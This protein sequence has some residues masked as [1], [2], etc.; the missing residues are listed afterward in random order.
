MVFELISINSKIKKESLR[1][2]SAILLVIILLLGTGSVVGLSNLSPQKIYAQTDSSN[3]TDGTANTTEDTLG[4]GG[5]ISG[6]FLSTGSC[7]VSDVLLND[8]NSILCDPS[9]GTNCTLYLNSS[10]VAPADT[11]VPANGQIETEVPPTDQGNMS[12]IPL[13]EFEN[14]TSLGP[15]TETPPGETP[16]GILPGLFCGDGSVPTL[17]GCADGSIPRPGKSGDV[18]S[19]KDITGKSCGPPPFLVRC[20]PGPLTG[21]I[22][23]DPAICNSPRPIPYV[24]LPGLVPESPVWNLSYS[25]I[26]GKGL[27]MKNIKAGGV[28]VYDEVSVPHFEF[29][30]HDEFG[31]INRKIVKFCDSTDG[32]LNL[33]FLPPLQ[34]DLGS[35]G[36]GDHLSWSFSKIYQNDSKKSLSPIG[37]L[38][39]TYDVLIRNGKVTNCEFSSGDCFR[40]IPKVTYL[41]TPEPGSAKLASFSAFYKFDYGV[42]TAIALVK[43]LNRVDKLIKTTAGFA[44]EFVLN[45]MSFVGVD[46]NMLTDSPNCCGTFDN[47]HTAHPPPGGNTVEIPGCRFSKFDC[48]HMHWRWSESNSFLGAVDVMVEP[49]TDSTIDGSL[50]GQP[51]L[52]SKEPLPIP[53][54]CSTEPY[55][56]AKLLEKQK[57]EITIVKAHPG[58]ASEDDPADPRFELVDTPPETLA[59]QI[60]FEGTPGSTAKPISFGVQVTSADHPILWYEATSKQPFT[61]VFFRHGTYVIDRSN[62]CPSGT[63]PGTDSAGK[64]KCI[65]PDFTRELPGIKLPLASPPPVSDEPVPKTL[66]P[67]DPS[68][69]TLRVGSS[70]PKVENLQRLLFEKGFDAGTIDGKFGPLTA[71]AVSQFQKDRSLTVDGI[72]GPET[73]NALCSS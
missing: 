53:P 55:V 27:V 37:T 42:K 34:T 41:W 16:A 45:E 11:G 68:S 73:W 18:L 22:P 62:V 33:P 50:R 5:A 66:E 32:S 15:G 28:A 4:A 25:L 61:D 46:P 54:K 13:S 43:D 20:I 30:F 9:N 3:G 36:K 8:D 48:A 70:G 67:C 23:V 47:I 64:F 7:S 57:I 14:S 38:K 2:A 29:S 56:C 17:T 40:F 63:F 21:P 19:E 10:Q 51:Y 52:I 60:P 35:L 59:T 31:G 71:S 44:K 24:P 39:I 26:Q 1:P 12:M 65:T 6:C 58:V 69:E 49:S 72:V